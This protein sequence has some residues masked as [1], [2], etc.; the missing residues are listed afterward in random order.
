MFHIY[1]CP[2]RA[3]RNDIISNYP[4]DNESSRKHKIV[5]I[6]VPDSRQ[7]KY[8]LT[9]SIDASHKRN[10]LKILQLRQP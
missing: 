10:V 7:A 1:A 6:N 2:L 5:S 9:R 8:P 3:N 4:T